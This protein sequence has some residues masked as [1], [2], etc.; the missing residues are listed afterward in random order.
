[1]TMRYY[2]PSISHLPLKYSHTSLNGQN[3]HT[4]FTLHRY[5]TTT[6]SLPPYH[7]L[8]TDLIGSDAAK[9]K[10][11][12]E[13]PDKPMVVVVA[14]EGLTSADAKKLLIDAGLWYI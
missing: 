4:P 7:V 5:G 13:A 12:V 10:A 9:L 3:S 11:A 14:Y 2:M 8:H 6:F 1:M